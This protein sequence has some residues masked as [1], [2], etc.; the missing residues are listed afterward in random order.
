MHG[1]TPSTI[2]SFGRKTVLQETVFGGFKTVITFKEDF[3]N[4]ASSSWHFE[5]IFEDY[6]VTF[7]GSDVPVNAGLIVFRLGWAAPYIRR[8][9]VIDAGGSPYT[10]YR[11]FNLPPP[12][13]DYWNKNDAPAPA[14]PFA[15]TA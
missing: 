12:P 9:I 11:A 8:A 13:S 10:E 4:W 7:P 3:W 5:D 6:Y 2:V 14:T 1:W 15:Y